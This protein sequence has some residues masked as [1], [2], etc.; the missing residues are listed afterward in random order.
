MPTPKAWASPNPT[1]VTAKN[2]V[3]DPPG[4]VGECAVSLARWRWQSAASAPP[5]TWHL[6]PDTPLKPQTRVSTPPLP[7]PNGDTPNAKGRTHGLIGLAGGWPGACSDRNPCRSRKLKPTLEKKGR[8]QNSRVSV[9][10]LISPM[11][12][13]PMNPHNRVANPQHREVNQQ[14]IVQV[15]QFLPLGSGFLPAGGSRY[16]TSLPET[17]LLRRST[18]GNRTSG[19]SDRSA[20]RPVTTTTTWVPIKAP[21]RVQSFRC[22]NCM[23]VHDRASSSSGVV[24]IQSK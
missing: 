22:V 23:A 17:R 3:P 1:A 19:L 9:V 5:A 20:I 8:M 14:L 15:R 2:A 7:H 4:F 21:I 18:T 12:E 6:T 11:P 13:G 16:P 24:T 10:W